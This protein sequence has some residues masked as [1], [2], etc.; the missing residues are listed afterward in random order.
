LRR[1]YHFFQ[2]DPYYFSHN[3]ILHVFVILKYTTFF[4]L[5]FHTIK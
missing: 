4:S 3:L 1:N 2:F 5:T